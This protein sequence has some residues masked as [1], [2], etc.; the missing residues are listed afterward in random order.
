MAYIEVGENETLDAAMVRFKKK[1]DDEGIL[2]V[3]REH[4]FFTKPSLKRHQAIVKAK[5]RMKKGA[6]K[7]GKQSKY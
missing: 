7:S 1:Q 3:W 4:E 5:R 2:K 6:K